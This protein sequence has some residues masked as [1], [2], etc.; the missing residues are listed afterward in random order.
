[1]QGSHLMKKFRTSRTFPAG[2]ALSACEGPQS[3]FEAAGAEAARV[4]TLFWV[5]LIGAVAIWAVVVAIGYYVTKTHPGQHS[6]KAG[7]R[8]IIWGGC[9]FP[10]VVLAMLLFWGLRMMPDLRRPGDGPTIAV[11]GERFWWRRLRARW[12]RYPDE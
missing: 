4:L 3:A 5:M 6:E 2:F 7:L 1:M 8:L 12:T 11:S 10:T 9:V